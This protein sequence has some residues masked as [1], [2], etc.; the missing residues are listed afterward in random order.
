MFLKADGITIEYS[1]DS[2][3]TW[4]DYDATDSQKT[5]LFSN[6][7]NFI[8]GKADSSNKATSDY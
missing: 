8:I 7:A 2:G 1:R 3:S 4:T 5:G 6:G